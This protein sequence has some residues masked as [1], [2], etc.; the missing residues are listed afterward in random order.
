[1]VHLGLHFLDAEKLWELATP[2]TIPLVDVGWVLNPHTGFD[3]DTALQRLAGSCNLLWSVGHNP[4]PYLRLD[5]TP[6][7]TLG[8]DQAYLDAAV[9]AMQWW[10]G[11]P[12]ARLTIICG[13]EFNHPAE[14]SL[15]AA[16]VAPI[17]RNVVAERDNLGAD[18]K[19]CAPAVAPWVALDVEE[20]NDRYPGPT[21]EWKNQQYA[22]ALHL[23]GLNIQFVAHAYSRDTGQFGNTE[24]LTD[25]WFGIDRYREG[26][27]AGFRVWR[28]F[29]EAI[30]ASRPSAQIFISEMNSH[31]DQPSAITY[32]PG[33]LQNMCADLDNPPPGIEILGATWF[34]GEP[35]GEPWAQDSTK[36]RLGQCQYADQDFNSIVLYS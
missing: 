14:G 11:A 2:K 21:T 10:T 15:Q 19:I 20:D 23:S 31:T 9:Y 17:V 28:D 30:Q 8:T 1:M 33:L 4:Q 36:L 3:L 18:V 26:Q 22:L 16:Y 27:Q 5:L 29:A 25:Y 6:G 32:V 13:N 24:P 12:R 35:H 34:V 7:Q